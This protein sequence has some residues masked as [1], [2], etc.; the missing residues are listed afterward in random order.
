MS[1]HHQKFRLLPQP[2]MGASVHPLL[3]Q[4]VQDAQT[5]GEYGA[6]GSTLWMALHHPKATIHSAEHSDH[7]FR[8]V[9][10]GLAGLAYG[11][12]QLAAVTVH[13]ASDV[14][15]EYART[16]IPYA[17]FDF[18]LCDGLDDG[19]NHVL[20]RAHRLLKPG[21]VIWVDNAEGFAPGI[22]AAEA[23]GVVQEAGGTIP[24]GRFITEFWVGRNQCD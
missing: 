15:L 10:D 20:Q 16:L 3:L 6:G 2:W 18:V 9:T 11:K 4:Y 13:K 8:L 22:E 14:G 19:R 23:N 5:I 21:G 17:P 24:D 1:N 12:F 7:W